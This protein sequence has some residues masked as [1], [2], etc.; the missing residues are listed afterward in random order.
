MGSVVTALG[1]LAVAGTGGLAVLAAPTGVLGSVGVG[2]VW[3][4]GRWVWRWAWAKVQGGKGRKG[5]VS[6]REEGA[7][8]AG[9]ERRTGRDELVEV[10]W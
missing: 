10:P 5:G 4:V 2:V 9:V 6:V 3:G 8:V 1:S 7:G